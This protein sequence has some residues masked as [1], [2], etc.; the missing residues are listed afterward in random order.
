MPLWGEWKAK[1]KD[2]GSSGGAL[3]D[4]IIHDIDYASFLVGEPEAVEYN[5]L[6]G[7]LSKH[8]Y[9]NATWQ[10]A[11]KE[12]TVKIEGGNIFHSNYAFRAG[13]SAVFE[14]AT[15]SFATDDGDNI[16]ID[17]DEEKKVIPAND[18]GDGYLRMAYFLL[19]RRKSRVGNR[20]A[21]NGRDVEPFGGRYDFDH[22]FQ[23]G[24]TGKKRPD[25]LGIG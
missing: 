3:F 15:V 25:Y 1:Q 8:D 14:K 23:G 10:F 24:S 6:P 7:K 5:I 4:L 22:L 12:L 21:F 9:L 11:S 19:W 16:C 2:F 18:L 17:T 20:G 13:Y